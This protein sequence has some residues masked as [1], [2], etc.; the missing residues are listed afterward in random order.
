MLFITTSIG[1]LG[2]PRTS[3]GLWYRLSH[4][5][6]RLAMENF[7][8]TCETARSCAEAFICHVAQR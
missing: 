8:G 5:I 2:D 7:K 6:Y 3:T 1:Q 4:D